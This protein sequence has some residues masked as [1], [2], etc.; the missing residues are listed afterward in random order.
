MSL[1]PERAKTTQWIS[2]QDH[3]LWYNTAGI[4]KDLETL[5]FEKFFQRI[6]VLTI[7]QGYEGNISEVVILLYLLLLHWV[8]KTHA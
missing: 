8:L 6:S 2:H 4:L 5:R 3:T 1:L 7:L